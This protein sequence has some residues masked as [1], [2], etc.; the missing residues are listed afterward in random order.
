M[1][2]DRDDEAELVRQRKSKIAFHVGGSIAALTPCAFLAYGVWSLSSRPENIMVSDSL[3]ELSLAEQV[4]FIF[5][6]APCFPLMFLP[7]VSGVLYKVVGRF[8]MTPYVGL[9]AL[10]GNL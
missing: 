4:G 2:H 3:D 6:I 9:D 10:K 7:L 1:K 5:F 8:C